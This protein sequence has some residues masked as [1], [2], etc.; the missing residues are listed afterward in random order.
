AAV[1]APR[2]GASPTLASIQTHCREHVAG[3][4]IPRELHL[5]PAVERSPSGKPDYRWAQRVAEGAVESPS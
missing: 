2:E 1:V 5:V 4:K 3:Y